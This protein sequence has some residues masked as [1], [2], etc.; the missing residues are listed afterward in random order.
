M[1]G[2]AAKQENADDSCYKYVFFCFHNVKPFKL[3]CGQIQNCGSDP[4]WWWAPAYTSTEE[5]DCCTSQS[6]G[7][8]ENVST[9]M[10]AFLFVTGHLPE[11]VRP[12]GQ[13]ELI[14][15]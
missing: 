10:K 14:D 15:I 6:Y 4:L 8:K 11:A 7:D 5:T 2:T 13:M 12:W 1:A 3:P 9:L